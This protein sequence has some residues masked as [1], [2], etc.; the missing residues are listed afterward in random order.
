MKKSRSWS[1]GSIGPCVSIWSDFVASENIEDIKLFEMIW[2]FYSTFD[3][4]STKGVL[5][6][7]FNIYCFT[8][9]AK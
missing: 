4:S 8:S 2:E 3:V 5:K 6:I 9:L 7:S 1:E